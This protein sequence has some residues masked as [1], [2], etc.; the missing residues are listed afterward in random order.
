LKETV[1]KQIS[2]L[3]YDI[4][5]EKENCIN[6]TPGKAMKTQDAAIGD[7]EWSEAVDKFLGY[8]HH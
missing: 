1:M 4:S 5:N 8:T 2:C 7:D 3:F 6:L